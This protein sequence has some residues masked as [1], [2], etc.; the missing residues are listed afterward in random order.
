MENGY[1]E[2]C[3]RGAS[4]KSKNAKEIKKTLAFFDFRTFD[5]Q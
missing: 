1:E 4:K 5:S 3:T 2:G